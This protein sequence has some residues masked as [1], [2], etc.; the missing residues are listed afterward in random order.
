MNNA[1]DNFN[2][3][4]I[5]LKNCCTFQHNATP[6]VLISRSLFYFIFR[7][8]KRSKKFIF[9]P[10]TK[11][12]HKQTYRKCSAVI[13]T[14]HQTSQKIVPVR[15]SLDHRISIPNH[16][17]RTTTKNKQIMIWWRGKCIKFHFYHNYKHLAS[18]ATCSTNRRWNREVHYQ[19]SSQVCSFVDN[20]YTPKKDRSPIK[21]NLSNMDSDFAAFTCGTYLISV[22]HNLI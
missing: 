15:T 18:F 16:L 12:D 19:Y 5:C 6:F 7:K 3:N 17:S 13:G 20:S 14:K 4:A 1:G 9:I 22:M 2:I 11:F 21:P 8:V 10:P